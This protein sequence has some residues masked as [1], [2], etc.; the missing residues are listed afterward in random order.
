MVALGIEPNYFVVTAT[1]EDYEEMISVFLTLENNDTANS[2][3]GKQ[4]F[5]QNVSRE[6][7]NW[8]VC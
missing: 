5:I 6:K 7:Y 8:A 2:N 3:P 4:A 1:F